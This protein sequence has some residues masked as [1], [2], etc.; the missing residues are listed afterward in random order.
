MIGWAKPVPV[1]P[2]NLRNPK[3]DDI[4]ISMAGPWMNLLLAVVLVGLARI[5]LLAD[6]TS[7]VEFL[8]QSAGLSLLLCF[9]NLIPVPPLDGSHVMRIVVGMSRETYMY[10][11]RFGFIVVILLLQVQ[12]IRNGLGNITFYTLKIIAGWFGMGGRIG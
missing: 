11:A 3:L 5:G 4:L 1:N 12:P 10:L 2:S 7:L 9:F 8:L 6:A